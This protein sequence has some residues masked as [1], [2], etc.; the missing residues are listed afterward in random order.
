MPVNR[1]QRSNACLVCQSKVSRAKWYWF[2]KLKPL[3]CV[4]FSA[5]Q[6]KE[7]KD[8]LATEEFHVPLLYL[9]EE[10]IMKM[11]WGKSVS[12][13]TLI[14]WYWM[15]F[16]WKRCLFSW[17]SIK[18]SDFQKKCVNARIFVFVEREKGSWICSHKSINNCWV[19]DNCGFVRLNWHGPFFQ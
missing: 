5:F 17:F 1:D 11:T 4:S 10:S 7:D 18:L 15:L 12:T 6:L 8:F 19:V 3:L 16:M 2:D 14:Y 9:K 13:N